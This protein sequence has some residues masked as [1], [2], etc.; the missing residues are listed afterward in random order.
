MDALVSTQTSGRTT[1]AIALRVGVGLSQEDKDK[2]MTQLAVLVARLRE[3][4]RT[5]TEQRRTLLATI[6]AAFYQ[7]SYRSETRRKWTTT[8]QDIHDLLAK[9]LKN[10]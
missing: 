2:T 7:S 8:D 5:L 10:A 6:Q 1:E 4:N 3:Q 9:A